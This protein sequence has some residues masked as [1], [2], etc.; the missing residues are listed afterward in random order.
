MQ[1]D[2]LYSTFKVERGGQA[3]VSC[4][5]YAA[6]RVPLW[7][8]AAE[9]HLFNRTNDDALHT[10]LA[11]V[12]GTFTACVHNY[13]LEPIGEA[14]LGEAALGASDGSFPVDLEV[15][16]GGVVALCRRRELRL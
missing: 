4:A 9:I 14:T 13:D 5:R 7:P 16:Q 15:P 8:A 3:F 6:L 12:E 1:N 11:G 2:N 10:I